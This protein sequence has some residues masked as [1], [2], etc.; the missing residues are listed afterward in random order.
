MRILRLA[1]LST[2]ALG[3]AIWLATDRAYKYA[4]ESFTE[5]QSALKQ[6]EEEQQ[7]ADFS[8]ETPV[9]HVEDKV[10]MEGDIG[11]WEKTLSQATALYRKYPELDELD[12]RVRF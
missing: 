12:G 9:T 6:F 5:K 1:L 8:R 10:R 4:L 7:V 2:M 3:R 11:G